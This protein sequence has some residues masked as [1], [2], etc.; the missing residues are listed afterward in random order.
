MRP[1]GSDA[2][3]YKTSDLRDLRLQIVYN[4]SR[5]VTE[6]TGRQVTEITGQVSEQSS[7]IRITFRMCSLGWD[8]GGQGVKNSEKGIT[9]Q[10]SR[11]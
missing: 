2:F 7:A 9:T 8:S 6:I 4:H 3:R 1:I 10:Y 11:L 5:M